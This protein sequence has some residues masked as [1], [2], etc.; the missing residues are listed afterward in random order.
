MKRA[1]AGW[2]AAFCTAMLAAASPALAELKLAPLFVDGAVLQRERPVA[3]WGW[4]D[5]GQTV[6]VS[7]HDQ[8]AGA[9]AD[10]K[11]R[12]QATLSAMP[13]S[14]DGANLTVTSSAEKLTVKDVLVGEVW[15]CS[16]QSN[17]Q[18]T[19]KQADN[20]EREIA[21]ANFPLIRHYRVPNVHAAEPAETFKPGRWVTATPQTV[22]TFS[23]VAYYFARDLHRDLK[24]PIGL[25]NTSW[26]GKMIEVF[27]SADVLASRPEF[28]KV[29][30]RWEQEQAELPAKQAEYKKKLAEYEKDPAKNPKPS[31]PQW[32]VD[33]HRPSCV[34]N[35][36]VAP[37]IPY[38]L[39]GV[40]WY[41]GEH[42]I[43]RASEYTLQ[44]TSMITDWRQ[45][46]DPSTGSGQAMP[47]YFCQLS[48]FEAPFDKSH[49]GYAQLRQAQLEATKLES[50]GMAVTFD[51]GTPGTVH[52]TNKQ[53]VGARLA[54][55]ARAKTYNLG[56]E[57]SGPALRSA[58]RVK[59]GVRLSFDHADR[60]TLRD[61]GSFEVA[62]ADGRF[63]PTEA[64]VSGTDVVLR[65]ASP[66]DVKTVRYAW[67]NA[68]KATLFN[69]EGLPAS[70]FRY[71]L[72][73]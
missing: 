47:F 67:G 40:I 50:T 70:P 72:T 28:K 21:S 2:F 17:M 65:C 1:F 60:F 3:V 46:F 59:D 10:A 61:G 51:V 68:P 37:C 55:I 11:G 54:R 6:T 69:G 38:T 52:P 34:Y 22:G 7:F 15:M 36:L 56:G 29:F 32:V 27:M 64:S 39:R 20:A 48:T 26:G 12:W 71:T 4:A 9:T 57:W 42:N 31:D 33:Q 44:F 63:Q 53:D 14:A 25:I 35:G 73:E 5:A 43:S 18:W 16:G 49:E 24:V 62:G 13:A 41:Q 23:A 45:K 58:V 66:W 8:S 30:D 19:V